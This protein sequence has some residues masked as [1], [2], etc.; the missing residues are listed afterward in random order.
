MLIS[1]GL[2]GGHSALTGLGELGAPKSDAARLSSRKSLSGPRRYQGAFFL[3]K[4]R[5]EMQNEWVDVSAQLSHHERHPMG[6]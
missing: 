3:R 6:H 4:G 2:D 1:T 5:E